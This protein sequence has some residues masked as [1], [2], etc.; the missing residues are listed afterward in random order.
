MTHAHTLHKFSSRQLSNLALSRM[1]SCEG[2][3]T[4]SVWPSDLLISTTPHQSTKTTFRTSLNHTHSHGQV[5]QIN[6]STSSLKPD[7]HHCP[8]PTNFAPQPSSSSQHLLPTPQSNSSDPYRSE[9]SS[10][11][12]PPPPG[13]VHFVAGG[14]VFH[15]LILPSF[16]L[17]FVIKKKTLTSCLSIHFNLSWQTQ[18][19]R[20]NV[21]SNCDGT[22]WFS[23]DSITIFNVSSIWTYEVINSTS[24]KKNKWENLSS[25]CWYWSYDTVSR[26]RLPFNKTLSQDFVVRPELPTHFTRSS[27]C[28]C[29][30]NVFPVS[31]KRSTKP[32]P[33]LGSST[34]TDKK[35]RDI[36]RTEGL[37]ALFRG[38]GP[39]LAGAMPARSINF[40]VYG[41]GKEFYSQKLLKKSGEDSSSLIHICAA[42]TA[43][44]ATA[45]A[46]NPIW[47]VKTRL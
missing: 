1:R 47:V 34:T 32:T 33:L 39:T 44:I 4:E 26:D 16:K 11:S 20:W 41:T 5:P 29:L 42:I 19:T 12:P 17:I 6:M 18:K 43:G 24:W 7:H 2:D 27:F 13:W 14:S 30:P 45:T 36:Q 10:R 38:L 15:Y 25:F 8:S 31:A 23:Q 21:W 35:K 3:F 9:P 28:P 40:Y 46:T 37:R 22:F